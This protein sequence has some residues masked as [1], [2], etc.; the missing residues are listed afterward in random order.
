[1]AD[2]AQ[3]GSHNSHNGAASMDP[4]GAASNANYFENVNMGNMESLATAAQQQAPSPYS[5]HGAANNQGALVDP[6]F[7]MN[8]QQ[9]PQQGYYQQQSYVQGIAGYPTPTPEQWQQALAQQLTSGMEI[10]QLFGH[11]Q[12]QNQQQAQQQ[13]Q[14][15]QAHLLALQQRGQQQVAVGALAQGNMVQG[16]GMVQQH[17]IHAQ[18]PVM[19]T[20]Q[21]VYPQQQVQ[22][23]QRQQQRV[24][25][26][27][28]INT[29][30]LHSAPQVHG[31]S[32]S[33]NLSSPLSNIETTTP[34][35]LDS[36]IARPISTPTVRTV[37]DRTLTKGRADFR[38]K[39]AI[40]QD[41][42]AEEYAR[43]CIQAAFAS[44][45]PPYALHP[46]EYLL[47]RDHINH[48]QVTTYIHIRN[49]IL[50]LWQR[51]PLVSVTR[52]EA[53]GC[54]KDYRFFDVAEVAYEWLV[55]NGYINF[56]CVEVPSTF[57]VS[58]TS[59]KQR[60]R[61]IVIIGAGM[62]GLGCARQL[63]GLFSQ[64]GDRL[65]LGEAPPNIIVLEARGRL[66]GRIY[67][68][69][70]KNQSGAS[71][72]EGK[73]ATADLGA[74][75]IT[76][77]DNGNPLGVLIRGQLALH[78]HSLQDNSSLYDSD[79]VPV[80]KERDIRVE[81]LYN[82]ILDR[83]SIFK[84]KLPSPKTIDGDKE[85]IETGKDPTGDGGDMIS[86]L[87]ANEV[88]IPPVPE[89]EL[90]LD[91][92]FSANVDKLTGKPST[93]TGSSARIPAAEAAR[94]LGWTLKPGTTGQE[95]ITLEPHGSDSRHPTLGKTMDSVLRQYQ[96]IIDLTPQDLRLMNWHYAN[97]EYAN[98]SNV[99][100]LS[101]GHWDQD[102]GND[103]SG[104]HAML[105][106]GYTQLPRGLWMSPRKLDIRTRH[107]VRKITYEEGGAR[108]E[109]ENEQ[110]FQADKVVVTLPLGVL[111]AEQVRF[112]PALPDWKLGA[113]ERLGYGLL[114]K[115][116]LVYNVPFWD[117]END[118][119]GLLHEPMGHPMMQ[120]SYE[121]NRGITSQLMDFLTH[122]LIL[123]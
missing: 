90:A 7:Y 18:S 31:A 48:I 77:F 107:V 37:P 110:V 21:K 14:Q 23:Q 11:I 88:A 85:L 106:G 52:E 98:A 97:L 99:D 6:M 51:N 62:S 101:L 112:E 64:F 25:Q 111:K 104:A 63:E 57:P 44:R 1:M 96:N 67:S 2:P 38:P 60:R 116:I 122:L 10:Q 86:K 80:N 84:H 123:C 87:E 72:P 19:H 27:P 105:L 12:Y 53:A 73:R 42:T 117:T 50:R 78:H 28:Q 81:R 56:G 36:A 91:D 92:N 43:Q 17:V 30:T 95:T 70:L 34:M 20:Q 16:S 114:N 45:L 113:I 4:N 8:E 100:S 54:A 118:M 74:Q 71:L 75:V 13:A 55:R 109:C 103:F 32:E 58:M 15:Q 69:P 121:A 46:A 79:G 5:P 33:S 3:Q 119:V 94:R 61:N 115:V 40:P 29:G 39:T 59:A 47:L 35:D 26:R 93:A 65:P 89:L 9:Q 68:H 83:V 41:L 49:G 66:G 102:D 76:G 82:D 24:Q 108:I 120:E 22:H